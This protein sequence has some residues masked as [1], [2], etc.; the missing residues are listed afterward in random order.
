MP[1]QKI[2]R[3]LKI[4]KY[5]E[6]P[7]EKNIIA[8]LQAIFEENLIIDPYFFLDSLQKELFIKKY[9][10]RTIK[11]YVCY[12]RDFLLFVGKKPKE[13]ENEDIKKY[14]DYMIVRKKVST[15]TLNIIINALKFYY[16]KF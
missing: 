12:N 9:S 3:Y 14:L 1:I 11:S 8:K 7:Y 16:G 6:I 5:W 10:R 4:E 2:V 13:V 15:S